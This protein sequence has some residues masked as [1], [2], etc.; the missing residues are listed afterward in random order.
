MIKSIILISNYNLIQN[1]LLALEIALEITDYI[2][3]NFKIFYEN[4]SNKLNSNPI[5]KEWKFDTYILI[6]YNNSLYY[7]HLKK[8]K[9][10]TFFIIQI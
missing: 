4:P 1:L 9:S 2:L 8:S 6:K 3:P 10:D 7:N 5:K